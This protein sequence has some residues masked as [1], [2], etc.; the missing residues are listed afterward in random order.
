MASGDRDKDVVGED[1]YK[2]QTCKSARTLAAE[3]TARRHPVSHTKVT[4]LLREGGYL[5]LIHIS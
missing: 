5:S 4:Q 1:V 2:R 3:L